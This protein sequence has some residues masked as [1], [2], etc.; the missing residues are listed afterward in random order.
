MP[1]VAVRPATRDDLPEILRVVNLAYRVEAFFKVGDRIDLA[2]LDERLARPDSGYLVIDGP[3]PGTLLATVHF[4]LRG[5]HGW[6]GLLAVDPAAQGRGYARALVEAMEARCRRAGV[7]WL[8]LDIVNL[9]SD[10]P[11]FYARLGFR[12]NGTRPFHGG[13]EVLLP[14]ELVVYVK[15]IVPGGDSVL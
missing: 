10:L 8:E 9:R 1:A 6:F 11:A 13:Q 12:E 5:S 14:V 4:E 2:G 15:P 7:A 3:A